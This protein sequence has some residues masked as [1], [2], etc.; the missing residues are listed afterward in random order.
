MSLI[1]IKS[2]SLN[3]KLLCILKWI[4]LIIIVL[5]VWLHL[6]LNYHESN[7]DQTVNSNKLFNNINK[8]N[9]SHTSDESVNRIKET[10]N[11]INAKQKVLNEE[12]YGPL[13]HN[14][15]VIIVQVHNRVNY[16]SAL[17]KSLEQTKYI[18]DVLLV[19]SHDVYDNQI[20]S[21]VNSIKFCKVSQ[22]LFAF[23][24]YMNRFI[25][26][27]FI[28]RLSKFSIRFHCN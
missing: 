6:R 8:Y 28:Y 7:S 15:I 10:I 11:E 12:I 14:D 21:I 5:F 24:N 19:F 13:K 26:Q 22:T 3:R 17:I 9:K 16:L 4:P 2:Y 27:S 23:N 25:N 1:L 20:N 18:N